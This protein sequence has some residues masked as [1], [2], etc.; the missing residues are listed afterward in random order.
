VAAAVKLF[1]DLFIDN[2]GSGVGTT[3]LQVAAH[4]CSMQ[5]GALVAAIQPLLGS[6]CDVAAQATVSGSCT[7]GCIANVLRGVVAVVVVMGCGDDGDNG[8]G[9]VFV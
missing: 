6:L 5:P 1:V 7:A 9:C 4:C 3:A 2:V 8:G